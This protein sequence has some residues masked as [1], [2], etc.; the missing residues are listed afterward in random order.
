MIEVTVTNQQ[1]A[2]EIDPQRTED[3]VRATLVEG[4]CSRASIGVAIV[5]DETIHEL[6]R[7]HLDHDYPTDVLSFLLERDE[8]GLEGEIVC[9]GPTAARSAGEY[10]WSA[11]E[12]LLLYVVH[13]T[14]HLLGYDDT[15]A[16]ATAKMRAAE[17]RC[18]KKLHIE[19]P[20]GPVPLVEGDT[21][22]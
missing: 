13:G 9:S 15:T 14:L 4:S 22:R 18:L 20:G 12:E 5:D 17:R 11:A 10:G 19:P 8:S 7:R 3:A 16:E 2:V 21:P 6:N 1:A